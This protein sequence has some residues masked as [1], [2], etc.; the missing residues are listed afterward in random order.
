M[1]IWSGHHCIFYPFR[2]TS[3][4]YS[5]LRVSGL[6]I[7]RKADREFHSYIPLLAYHPGDYEV[8][9]RQWGSEPFPSHLGAFSGPMIAG[10]DP[11]E[12]L[13]E[14]SSSWIKT[15]ASMSGIV[16]RVIN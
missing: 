11:E 13:L 9:L 16:H 8:L 10:L 3:N 12:I 4:P 15:L 7:R 5:T 1:I 6:F 2:E 14:K